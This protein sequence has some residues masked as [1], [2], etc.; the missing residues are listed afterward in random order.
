MATEGEIQASGQAPAAPA[1]LETSLTQ[2]L[3]ADSSAP[4]QSEAVA[5]VQAAPA[6][7]PSEWQGVRDFAAQQGIQ[8]PWADDVQAL[9]NLLQAYRRSTQPNYYAQLGQR[10]APH[11][12][13][14]QAYLKQQAQPAP[15]QPSAWQAPP[16]RREWLQMVEVDPETGQMRAKAGYDPALVEKV[17]AYSEWRDKF[18]Q[19][20]ESMI[21]PLVEQRAQ[22]IIDQKLAGFQEQRTA[23]SLVAREATWMFQGGQV[24]GPLTAA[25]QVYQRAAES[26]WQGGLR[27]VRSLHAAAVSMVQNAFLRQEMGKRQAGGSPATPAQEAAAPISVASALGRPGPATQAQ[28]VAS[29]LNRPAMSMRELMMARLKGVPDTAVT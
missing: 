10:L 20:P 11:A 15:T 21:G 13:Q 12:E 16:F 27:D 25:G 29:G 6:P 1:S 23:E 24:G 3:P 14:I 9:Q 18:L 19:E 22:A 26:L 17:Q 8:L 28:P 5:P 2:T 4:V 7:T